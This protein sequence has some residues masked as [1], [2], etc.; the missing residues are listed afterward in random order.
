MGGSLRAES[1]KG[2]GTVFYVDIEFK[3]KSVEMIERAAA[4]VKEAC[5]F[6]GIVILL[7]EDNE[8]NREIA[9]EFLEMANARVEC[10]ADG[11]E[12]FKKFRDSDPGHFDIIL[13]DM[14][15]P[16]WDGLEATRNIRALDRPDAKRITI[17]AVTANAYFEDE[18][19]CLEAGMDDHI[20]K[21]LDI[22]EFYKKVKKHLIS[23]IKEGEYND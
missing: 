21:P 5:D 23:K 10:A 19:K 13:M 20:A 11:V 8:L 1:T 22:Q 18:Q 2:I 17:I 3:Y 9:Y 14:Q 16:R 6:S 7:A 4:P 15:M 12:A